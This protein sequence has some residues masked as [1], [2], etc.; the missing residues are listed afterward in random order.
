MQSFLHNRPSV[1]HGGE[2]HSHKDQVFPQFQSKE[3]V[4][5]DSVTQSIPVTAQKHEVGEGHTPKIDVIFQDGKI[6]E[7]KVKC[8]CGTEIVMGVD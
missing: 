5:K 7:I 2:Q 4:E 1:G 8:T 3:K 6:S